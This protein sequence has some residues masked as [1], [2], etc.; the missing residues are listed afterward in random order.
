MTDHQ[1][2]ANLDP[3]AQLAQL[4][5]LLYKYINYGPYIKEFKVFFPI[6]SL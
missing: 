6:I 3:K 4:E 2:M 5:I 1:G